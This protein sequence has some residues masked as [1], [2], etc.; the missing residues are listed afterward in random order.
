MI[1]AARLGAAQD[2][3]VDLVKG[4]E[5]S[6]LEG[7][8]FD[9]IYLEGLF[10]PAYY[11]RLLEHL[12]A[13]R[14]YRELTHREAMQKDGHSARRKFYLFP[15]HI[16]L[17][18]AAQRRFW[19]ALSRELRSR[20]LQDA[21]KRKFRSALERRFGRGI[22]RLSFYPVPILLRD[23]SGYR[24]GIHGDGLRKAMTV[25]FY[26]PRDDSQA[27]L[28]TILH[29]GRDGEAAPRT[30]AL[31]F[32]PATGYAF[33]VLRHESWHSVARTS[34]ADGERNSLMLTYYVQDGLRD[35]LAQRLQRV[36][37]FLGYGLRR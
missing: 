24:I 22:E 29:E 30:K 9:H 18:P 31:A 5:A 11:R 12:P 32:R 17:L 1:S 13:T 20:A 37:V 10:S 28:G 7:R 3:S 25:Q 4:V 33:A 2:L 36:L 8:P 27:H 16:M 15:E 34:D 19:L 23:L 6:V 26:L 14:R 21:F 35:W